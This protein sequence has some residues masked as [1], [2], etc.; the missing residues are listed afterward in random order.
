[1]LDSVTDALQQA[2]SQPLGLL[3]AMVLGT[4]SA[5]TSTCC[6]L[7][8]LGVLI[9]YSGAQENTD[10]MLAFQKAL[11]FTL[12]TIVALIIIGGIAGFVGQVANASL[13]RYWKIF[14]GVVLIFF[15]LLTLKILPFKISFGQFDS[16]KNR[17]GMSGVMLTG[18]VLGGLVAI[19]SLCCSPVIFAVIGV[20]VLQGQS[21]Q[22]A[23]LLGMYAI[24]FS[25]PIGA[26]LLGVS[27][28]KACF[29]QNKADTIVRWLA[30]G[31]QLIVGFYFLLSF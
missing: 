21:L 6:T 26:I 9:G 24:G 30:G 2:A 20:A 12:G 19:T 16:I 25:L 17:F 11:F 27:L 3:L 8:A 18:F 4:L 10:R 7:P 13:G 31:I 14:A 22:A 1:M 5:A 28:S 15:G 23:L 29:L